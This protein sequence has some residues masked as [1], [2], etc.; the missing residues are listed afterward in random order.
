MNIDKKEQVFCERKNQRKAFSV[1]HS[2]FG[3][4]NDMK[5]KAWDLIT[6][7]NHE[8]NIK[9]GEKNFNR[10]NQKVLTAKMNVKGKN[11]RNWNNLN[12]AIKTTKMNIERK[13]KPKPVQKKKVKKIVQ[14]LEVELQGIGRN[15]GPLKMQNKEY[16]YKGQEKE[17]EKDKTKYEKDEIVLDSNDQYQYEAEYPKNVDWNES[18]IPMSGR[19]FTIIVK[20]SKPSLSTTKV[21]KLSI[22]E[23]YKTKDWNDSVKEKNEIKINMPPKK[24]I[25]LIKIK[26]IKFQLVN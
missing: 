19:P 10:F 11:K 3:F 12:K 13:P 23:S 25:F 18:T 8:M 6:I 24:V 16:N 7:E 20:K 1:E 21:E 22:K 5:N 2:E 26:F 4:H 15:F 14:E 17:K 9:G